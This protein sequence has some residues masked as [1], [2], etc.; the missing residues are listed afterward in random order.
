VHLAEVVGEV[1][2]APVAARGHGETGVCA[3]E[4]ACKGRALAAQCVEVILDPGT[5]V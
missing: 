2:Q 5:E 4:D 1:A 3:V